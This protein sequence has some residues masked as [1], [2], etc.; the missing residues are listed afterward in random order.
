MILET[1]RLKIVE[2]TE[3]S[4]QLAF[5]QRYDNGPFLTDYLV[6]LK[7][8]ATIAGWGSWLIVRKS[9]NLVI[10]DIG[11]KGKPNLNKVVEIG[12]GFLKSYWHKGYATEAANALIKWSF[13]T[14]KVNK[15]M[16]EVLKENLASIHVLEKIG[17]KRLTEVNEMYYYQIK[18]A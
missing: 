3:E 5:A 9:D 7:K 1:E 16:A 8:D 17:M 15:I 10:G 2:C 4:A 13:A 11:F 6:E 18:K 12:Y 14:D